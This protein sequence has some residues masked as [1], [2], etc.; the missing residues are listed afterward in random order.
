MTSRKFH[1]SV[2]VCFITA[3]PITKQSNTV[4]SLAH[5]CRKVATAHVWPALPPRRSSARLTADAPTSLHATCDQPQTP[6]EVVWARR[7]DVGNRLHPRNSAMYRISNK[8]LLLCFPLCSAAFSECSS[9]LA[10]T[11]LRCSCGQGGHPPRVS[12]D[13]RVSDLTCFLCGSSCS[14]RL[15]H[16]YIRTEMLC[17][18]F[19]VS[20]P[21]TAYVADTMMG[22]LD[23]TV[24]QVVLGQKPFCVFLLPPCD[25]SHLFSLL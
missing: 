6:T 15:L 21:P 8:H 25:L 4:R 11:S 14:S 20:T 17:I 13:L 24:G 19:N 2:C 23:P 1:G 9:T 5:S 18:Y 22:A 12:P 16:M 3:G 7:A 10:P